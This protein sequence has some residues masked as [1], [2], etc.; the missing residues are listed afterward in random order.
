MCK[1]AWFLNETDSKGERRRDRMYG[2]RALLRVFSKGLN[3]KY[4]EK[5]EKVE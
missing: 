1:S 5:K 4:K 3:I 2:Y